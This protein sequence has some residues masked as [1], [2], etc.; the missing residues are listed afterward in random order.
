MLPP[1]ARI[2]VVSPSG[3]F[4]PSR[5]IAGMEVLK[6]WGYCPE[7]L[8]VTAAVCAGETWRYLAAEDL[9]RKEELKT[10]FSGRYDAVWASRGGYGIARLLPDLHLDSWASVPFFGF[11][12]GTALLNPLARRGRPAVHAPVLQTLSDHIDEPSRKDLR[13]F[14]EGRPRPLAGTRWTPGEAQGPLV[15]GNL[16]MLASLCGT[17]EQLD[18]RD[19][20]VLLEEVTEAPYRVDRLLTQLL[21]SGSLIG[22]KAL[23]LGDFVK[24]DPPAGAGYSLEQ[25]LRERLEPLGLPILAGVPV[26]HG[27][28]NRPIKLGKV[29]LEGE[30]LR[31]EEPDRFS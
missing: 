12:D 17:P 31:P 5:L 10:A 27:A 14:L 9:A 22:A 18:A 15:G 20:V 30:L 11:S 21:Q 26:G 28:G 6:S 16:A 1:N 4:T 24:C 7:M 29:R 2:A 8:P 3:A 23:V 19:A 25:V 13:S